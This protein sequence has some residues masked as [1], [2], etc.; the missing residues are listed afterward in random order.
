MEAVHYNEDLLRMKHS[1]GFVAKATE[2]EGALSVYAQL[3]HKRAA[4]CE[5]Y[6]LTSDDCKLDLTLSDE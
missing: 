2:V 5:R 6:T 3:R 4:L 1:L